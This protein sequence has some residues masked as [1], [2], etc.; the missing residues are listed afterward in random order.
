M[1][2]LLRVELNF[3]HLVV[4]SVPRPALRMF[5]F[6]WKESGELRPRFYRMKENPINKFWEFVDPV[7]RNG[8]VNRD[9]VSD[10]LTVL[11]YIKARAYLS[12]DPKRIRKLGLNEVGYGGRLRVWVLPGSNTGSSAPW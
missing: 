6:E 4:F 10:I 1:D 7:H 11:N 12:R 9:R 2:N 5:E 8:K 3:L